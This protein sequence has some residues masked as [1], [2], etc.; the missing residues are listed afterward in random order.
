[1]NT[2]LCFFA[3]FLLV[4][5][6]Q[7]KLKDG[8]CDVCIKFLTKFDKTLSDAD[9]KDVSIVTEKFRKA[10]RKVKGKENR[11]C[12]YV[13]GT[14]DAATGIVSQVTKPLT[15]HK[16][17]DKICEDLKKKDPQICELQYDQE[18]DWNNVNLKKMRVKQLR[19]ILSDWDETCKGCVEKSDF[20]KKIEEVRQ[21]HTEL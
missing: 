19:K 13:G 5:T 2:Y 12:Y 17:M 9:R 15:F 3:V 4:L 8:D 11:F 7:A 16:P 18:I 10:C 14:D 6:V 21:Q 1:M 20:I